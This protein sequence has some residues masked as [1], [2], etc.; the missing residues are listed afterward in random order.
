EPKGTIS[1]F[2]LV[3]MRNRLERGRLHKARRGEVFFRAPPRYIKLPSHRIAMGPPEQG[4][5]VVPLI[6]VKVDETAPAPGVFY[7]LIRTRI[8]LGFRPF[9]GPNRGNLEWRRPVLITVFE[10]LRHPI[11]A[12][13]YAYGRRTRR[14]ARAAAGAHAGKWVPM[15]QWEV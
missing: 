1:E 4:P 12:G 2:E 9:H 6:F 7:S 3:T 10:I 14:G 13:A 11:Y 5:D 8:R 15:E